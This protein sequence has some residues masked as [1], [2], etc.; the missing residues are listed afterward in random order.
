MVY[1]GVS[2][3]I[4]LIAIKRGICKRRTYLL[5]G[6]YAHAVGLFF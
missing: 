5:S 6:V 4:L 1:S 2:S 3:M